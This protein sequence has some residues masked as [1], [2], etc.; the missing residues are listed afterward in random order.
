MSVFGSAVPPVQVGVCALCH[1]PV[2]A[3][4]ALCFCCRTGAG[5]WG[6]DAPPA[7]VALALARNGDPL[8][9][10]LRGYKDAPGAAARRAHADALARFLTRQ[11]AGH[12]P[13][14]GAA[15]LRWDALAVVPSASGRRPD[16]PHPLVDLCGRVPLLAGA[17]H[18]DVRVRPGAVRRL[19][20]APAACTIAGNVAGRR[21]L[22]LDDAW[23]SGAHV[24]S[25]MG[26]L[27]RAGARVVGALVL[28]RLVD[29]SAAPTVASWWVRH[30]ARAPDATAASAR[31]C[32]ATC[33]TT[34]R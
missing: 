17:D 27:A 33:V 7:V 11:L 18:L 28:A 25:V 6:A 34:R 30:G 8:H 13:C 12:R 10:A 22:V 21:V 23:V 26:A 15:G 3:G 14:L 31:C 24:L 1:G 19:H 2:R 5:A 16:A 29:P 4:R 32:L 9:R 20:P